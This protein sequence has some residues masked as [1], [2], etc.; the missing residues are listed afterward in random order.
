M[1][2]R[3]HFR[4]PDYYEHCLQELISEAYAML[5]DFRS[6]TDPSPD[7]AARASMTADLICE[8]ID[9]FMERKYG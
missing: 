4:T 9:E 6:E 7:A 5:A 2:N 3:E 8:Q 1:L